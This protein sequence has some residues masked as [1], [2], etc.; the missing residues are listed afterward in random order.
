MV[1]TTSQ[2]AGSA[3]EFDTHKT[4]HR[5]DCFDVALDGP[6]PGPAGLAGSLA[7]VSVYLAVR[8]VVAV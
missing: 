8:V 3:N 2:L 5:R 6:K 1:K 7:S 4:E